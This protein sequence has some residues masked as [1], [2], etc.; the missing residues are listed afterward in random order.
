VVQK[1][2]NKAIEVIAASPSTGVDTITGEGLA[3]AFRGAEVAVDVSN[4]PSFE[5]KAATE[6][7]LTSGRNIFAAEKAAGV[8]HHVALSV[9][10]TERPLGIGYLRA[11]LAQENLIKASGVPYTILHSTQF[12]E[13]IDG[14]IKTGTEG[15]VVHVPSALVQP[16]ASD[17]VATALA[18]LA[19]SPPVND[20]IEIAGPDA[21]PLDEFAREYLAAKGDGRRVVGDI[22]ARYYG[23]EL[24]DDSLM[25]GDHPR[26]ASTSFTEWLGHASSQ[27]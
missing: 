22:H 26:F 14:I 4:S 24:D 21:C 15:N 20:T 27:M 25:P 10:G 7:F 1:L 2:R 19:L 11:K 17:D 8:K 13:F 6:F 12:F 18:Q 5:E 3:D 23:A 16:I 9:V